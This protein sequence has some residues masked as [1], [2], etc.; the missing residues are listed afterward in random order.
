MGRA[1]RS[2]PGSQAYSSGCKGVDSS[3][4]HS[5]CRVSVPVWYFLVVPSPIP[6]MFPLTDHGRDLLPG[7]NSGFSCLPVSSSVTWWQS[8][9]HPS[10]KK[11]C[12]S[13]YYRKPQSVII[14]NCGAQ[15]QLILLQPTPAPRAR[16]SL[17]KRR[18]K[19]CKSQRSREFAVRLCLLELLEKLHP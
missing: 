15:C 3:G 5:S 7:E 8:C 19:D 16:E 11:L 13:D 12:N 17:W 2:G 14:Q 1:G 6:S 18:R 4:E 9:P 10:S